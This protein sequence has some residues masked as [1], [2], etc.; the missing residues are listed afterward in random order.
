MTLRAAL[1]SLNNLKKVI[2]YF[3][4]DL[5]SHETKYL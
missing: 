3:H 2:Y 1:K 4:E 5:Y